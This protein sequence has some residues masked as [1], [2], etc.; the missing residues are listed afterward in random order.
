MSLFRQKS[1]IADENSPILAA[2]EKDATTTPVLA[3]ALVRVHI[4]WQ[5]LYGLAQEQSYHRSHILPPH[6]YHLTCVLLTFSSFFLL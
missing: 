2:E 1:E 4:N 5:H 6:T 3:A